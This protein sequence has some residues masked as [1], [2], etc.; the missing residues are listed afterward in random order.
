MMRRSSVKHSILMGAVLSAAALA[1]AIGNAQN[2]PPPAGQPSAVSCTR[3]GLQAAVNL[4]LDA[5]TKGDTSG[6]P[7]A[8][9]LDQSERRV[10]RSGG[11]NI[12]SAQDHSI[13]D[14]GADLW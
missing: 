3:V 11:R 7:L 14:G 10:F 1:P 2:A 5:Q 8:V 9:R 4:D 6:M 13:T 12:A